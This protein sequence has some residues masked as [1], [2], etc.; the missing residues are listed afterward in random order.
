MK[1]P[2]ERAHKH[3][4]ASKRAKNNLRLEEY[5]RKLTFPSRDGP[6]TPF[7]PLSQV[8]SVIRENS[9]V[10]GRSPKSRS[11]LRTASPT[12]ISPTQVISEGVNHAT[13]S[14]SDSSDSVP[15]SGGAQ[16]V[17]SVSEP[18][19]TPVQSLQSHVD[20]HK[21]V[22]DGKPQSYAA[23]ARSNL[24]SRQPSLSSDTVSLQR[25]SP[26]HPPLSDFGKLASTLD[27]GSDH[28][29]SYQGWFGIFEEGEFSGYVAGLPDLRYPPHVTDRLLELANQLYSTKICKHHHLCQ[30]NIQTIKQLAMRSDKP[31]IPASLANE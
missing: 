26:L 23:A 1:K 30:R 24:V 9:R 3:K 31:P 14:D 17:N 4:S 10:T 28:V 15:C 5:Q 27:A 20:S 25:Q 8:D 6:F 18:P 19:A 16:V 11:E 29:F 21:T 22:L 2:I 12:S 7:H 13:L